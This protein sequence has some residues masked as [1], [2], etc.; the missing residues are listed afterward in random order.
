MMRNLDMTTLRSFAAVA[1]HGGV[2]RAAASMNLTQSAVSMQLK[3]L[4]EMLGIELL[5]RSSRRVALTPPGEQL[6]V[7]ARRMVL[8]NDE[9][10]GRLTDKLYEGEVTL[11]VPHD[12]VYPVIPRVLRQFNAAYPRVKVQLISSY[13]TGLRA[14]HARGEIDL[15]LTTEAELTRGGE[16]LAEVPLR[17]IG[18]PG[19]TAWKQ[20]PLPLA[21]CRHCT[22]R[23]G[24][25]RKLDAAGIDWDLAVDSE[26][27]RTI[28]ATV[29]AD[30]AITSML[31][32]HA[33]PHLQMIPAGDGLPVLDRQRI[34]IYGG[35]SPGNDLV[36]HLAAMVRQGFAALRGSDSAA[37]A[38]ARG[39]TPASTAIDTLHEEAG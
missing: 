16:T 30:L 29:S 25:L 39:D 11:G 7:Y 13:T 37:A 28:E 17:W 15:I 1:E 32:G 33:P 31:E 12:I 14:A 38:S 34:N 20:R 4:E 9:A 3:R 24:D 27:D 6:L 36:A 8:L 5:D 2:T 21:Y 26:S 22:F 19:G 23:P 35:A 10:V 18:A